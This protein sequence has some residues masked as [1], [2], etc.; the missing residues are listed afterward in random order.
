MGLGLMKRATKTLLGWIALFLISFIPV[1]LWFNFSSGT[2]NFSSYESATH[3]LGELFGLVGMTLF[4]FTFVLSTR[5]KWIEDVFGGLDKVYISH[6]VLGG[7]SFVFVLAHPIFLV[8]KFIPERIDLAAT[9]ILPSGHWSVNFGIISL[10]GMLGL[11]F[12]TLFTKMRYHRWKYTHE[13]FGLFF[14]FAV[15]HI[16]MV[17]NTF[18]N[19]N[20]FYGYYIYAAVVSVVGILA[21]VYSLLIRNFVFKKYVYEIKSINRFGTCFEIIFSPKNR[22]L[23]YKAGQFIFVKFFNDKISKEAHPFSVASKS[24][25]GE[26][27]IIVKKLGDYTAKLDNLKV[28]DRVSIE[29]PYGKF[30]FGRDD[31]G[32]AVWIAGGIGITPFIGMAEDILENKDSRKVTLFHCVGF[33][34]DLAGRSLFEEVSKRCKNFIYVPWNSAKKKRRITIEDVYNLSGGFDGKN[35]FL[36]GSRALKRDIAKGLKEHGVKSK[37]IHE[38]EFDFK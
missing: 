17:R 36:C 25:E 18:A 2:D 37:D 15:L 23:L 27:K 6:A 24:N 11:I 4:A 16:F 35:F 21:F 30:N 28:G 33:E 14:V 1:F 13:F 34:E 31:S 3:S 5:M 9:Y 19:D 10:V 12:V 29:G 26:I 8:L 38:E 7:L 32:D 22:A 20:I